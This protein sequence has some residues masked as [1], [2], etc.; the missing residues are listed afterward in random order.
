M[1]RVHLWHLLV[2]E[3]RWGGAVGI[4]GGAGMMI[5]LTGRQ[6]GD[7]G[8]GGEQQH[9]VQQQQAAQQQRKRVE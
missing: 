8:S 6:Q 1:L 7:V 4:A 9:Q 3:V 2:V 5:D